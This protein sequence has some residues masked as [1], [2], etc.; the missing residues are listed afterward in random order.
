MKQ[1]VQVAYRGAVYSSSRSLP[2]R[3]T[4]R[5]SLAVSKVEGSLQIRHN[6]GQQTA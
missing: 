6:G 5:S 2:S 1:V 3:I 4:D